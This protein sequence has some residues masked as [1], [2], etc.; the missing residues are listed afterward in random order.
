[1]DTG[2][3]SQS[4]KQPSFFRFWHILT[5]SLQSGGGIAGACLAGGLA[6][7]PGIKIEIYE[8]T[9]AFAEIGAGI[10]VWKRT[11]DLLKKLGMEEHF[12]KISTFPK[13]DAANLAFHFRKSDQEHGQTFHTWELEGGMTTFHRA[14]FLDA[15]VK[16]LPAGC[17]HF[18]K[19]CVSYNQDQSQGL[20]SM[21]FEDGTTA[22]AD[23]VI[24]CDGIGSVIRGQMY[25]EEAKKHSDDSFLEYVHPIWSGRLAYRVVFP[26]AKLKEVSPSH[27]NLT[28][29]HM[30]CQTHILAYP[31]IQGTAIGL[32]AYNSDFTKEGTSLVKADLPIPSR[33][34]LKSHYAGWEQDV[35]DIL[36]KCAGSPPRW[37]VLS[38]KPLSFYVR[39]RVA[40]FGDAAHAT[41]PHQGSGA[42]LGVEDAFMLSRLL[43]DPSVNKQNLP[44]ALLA[45]ERARLPRTH[46]VMKGSR[47][48]GFIFEFNG[49]PGD[50]LELVG[51][52][53]EVLTEWITTTDPEEDVA[54]ALSWMKEQQSLAKVW[55]RWRFNDFI[56]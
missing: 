9:E 24:A 34:D 23:A 20:V 14:Q 26:S 8:A 56:N 48:C 15:L 22:V 4:C 55:V 46:H 31:V 17:A 2:S 35:Q 27:R 45:Y 44:I 25:R 7:H 43:G 30:V 6:R 41:T 12:M 18:E 1:M 38:L 37:A 33:E 50:N 21:K 5:I 52:E 19:K 28:T 29:P 16:A 47:Q 32:V 53:I 40:L 10:S 13:K 54:S 51:R 11:L 42:G 39:D 36:E 49:A 3:A